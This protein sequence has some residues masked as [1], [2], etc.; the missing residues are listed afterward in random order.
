M[1][2]QLTKDKPIDLSRRYAH[3]QD[4]KT[5]QELQRCLLV[6]LFLHFQA[7]RGLRTLNTGSRAKG[8]S[9]QLL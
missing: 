3:N 5:R 8:P 2:H 1:A 9:S 4:I 7:E 6:L